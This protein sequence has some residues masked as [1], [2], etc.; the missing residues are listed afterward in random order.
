MRWSIKS[1]PQQTFITN[2]TMQ[3]KLTWGMKDKVKVTIQIYPYK[4]KIRSMT[5]ISKSETHSRDQS[6]ND[7]EG[8]ELKSSGTDRVVSEI[9]I[10]NL[11]NS[12]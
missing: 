5:N 11:T 6:I 10:Q 7:I 12:E 9:I 1:K 8:V 3:K 4:E 2:K